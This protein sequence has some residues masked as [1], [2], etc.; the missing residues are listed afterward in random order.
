MK[1]LLVLICGIALLSSK[2]SADTVTYVLAHPEEKVVR[3]TAPA[4][5]GK[6]T[7]APTF[8]GGGVEE[9]RKWVAENVKHPEHAQSNRVERSVEVQFTI[10]TS[11]KVTDVKT[12]KGINQELNHEARRVVHASPKWIPATV[13]GKPVQVTYTIPVIF[14]VDK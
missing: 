13:N 3:S 12:V 11:G 10:D 2:A 4:H 14:L 9:F 6:D 8:Q 5:A 7:V 1:K